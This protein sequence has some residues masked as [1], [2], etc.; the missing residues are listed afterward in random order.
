M[1]RQQSDRKRHKFLVHTLFQ[2]SHTL[3]VLPVAKELI[4]RG[5]EVVWLGSPS[6]ESR[7]LE[8]GARFVAT[9][10]VADS[11]ARMMSNPI[12]DLQ[13]VAKAFFGDRLV[14]QVADLRRALADFPADCL[15]NDFAPQGAAALHALGEV[16]TYASITGTPLYTLAGAASH[17]PASA[18][19]GLLCM[20]QMLLPLINSQRESL[21]LPP[22]KDEDLPWLHHSPFL[23]LQ[24]S[25]PLLEFEQIVPDTTHFIGPLAGS[26][27]TQWQ[28]PPE[29]WTDITMSNSSSRVVI[30]LTQGTL[31]TDPSKLI[32]PVLDALLGTSNQLDL[33][34]FLVVA[35]PYVDL[36]KLNTGHTPH[37]TGRVHVHISAWVPYDLLL[38][39]CN[40]M[41]TNGGYGGVMQALEHGVPLICAGTVADHAD[42]G[43]R[44]AW[45]KAGLSLQTDAPSGEEIRDAIAEIL[46]NKSYKDNAST[47]G[48]QLKGLGGAKKAAD[49]LEKLASRAGRRQESNAYVS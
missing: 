43:A 18:I 19:G 13:G 32:L 21:G 22:V 47:V 41:V 15:L 27:A 37:S 39:H 46:D 35:T 44:V 33:D 10:E 31:V 40:L 17:P 36:V 29:W 14:A 24:A 25:A 11:D 12:F 28:D 6:E 48:S 26:T 23:H 2:K 20:P 38:P 3:I 5:H 45:A 1:S 8:S 4:A 30:G 42:V 49:L 7:I 34:V 9:K 16:P